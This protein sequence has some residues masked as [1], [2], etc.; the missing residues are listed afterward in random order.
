MQFNTYEI[1]R[2]QGGINDLVSV[3]ALP[4]VWS[5]HDSRTV[6]RTLLDALRSTLR[7]DFAYAR[8]GGTSCNL[9]EDARWQQPRDVSIGARALGQVITSFLERNRPTSAVRMPNPAGDGDVSIATSVIGIHEDAGV[10][11]AASARSDFPTPLEKLLIGV[12]ANQATIGLQ[13]AHRLDEQNRTAAELERRVAKGTA[14]LTEANQRLGDEVNER[15]QAE[16]GRLLL[17]SLV[18][19]SPDFVGM[20]SLDEQMLFVN[21]AGRRI[22]GLESG[23]DIARLTVTN[24]APESERDRLRDEILPHIWREGRWEGELLLWNRRTRAAIPMWHQ[25]FFITD[26]EDRRSALATISRDLT[27]RKDAEARIEAAQAQLARMARVTTMGELTAAIAHEVNQPLAA[28]VTNANACVRWLSRGEPNLAEAQAAAARIAAEGKR[29]SDVIGRVRTLMKKGSTP[30]GP[31][32]LNEIVLQV[33]DLI[34]PQVFRCGISLR[35]EIADDVP[36]VTGDAVQ[37][38]QVVLNLMM[39][40][41]EATA[42]QPPSEREILVWS[43]RAPTGDAEIAV[44]DSGVGFHS[45]HLEQLFTPFYSTKANGMGMGLAISRSIIEGHSGQLQAAA[46]QGPGATF[47]LSIPPR[48]VS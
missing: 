11:V 9:I 47:R 36:S 5:G 39:N 43:R 48:P 44:S 29:A 14:D 24:L 27:E 4:A 25:A 16:Q 8:A 13:E 31:V 6:I 19:N 28:V 20:A 30:T 46:N 38:Q 17:A 10:V 12:A 45:S 26:R 40:A 33:V 41:I 22:L 32:D 42:D 21:A 18:E 7:L 15:K 23:E 2:L 34:R 3:L 1:E 37:L 35:M